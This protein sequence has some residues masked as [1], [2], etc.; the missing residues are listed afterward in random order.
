MAGESTKAEV[1]KHLAAGAQIT[2][3]PKGKL[4]IGSAV[5]HVRFTTRAKGKGVVWSFNI[6][7]NTL[8]ADFELWICG[9]SATYYLIPKATVRKIY[10]DPAAYT[11]YTHPEIRVADI[12]AVTHLCTYGR[13]RSISLVS[14]FK[15]HL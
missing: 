5:V 3:L 7:P 9:S 15:G 8:T 1:V 14:Y 4:K 13:G 10:D 2:Q 6:N 12:S 11:D